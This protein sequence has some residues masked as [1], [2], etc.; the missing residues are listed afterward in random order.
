MAYSLKSRGGGG[1]KQ[2]QSK[3]QRDYD[4]KLKLCIQVHVGF[5]SEKNGLLIYV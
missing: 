1:D 4:K 3:V 2:I 5:F